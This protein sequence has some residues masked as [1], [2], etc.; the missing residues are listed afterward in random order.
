MPPASRNYP[1][2][3]IVGVGAVILR[4]QQVV[5]VRR[6]SEPLRGRWSLPGGRLELGETLRQGV[7]REVLEET[8]LQVVAKEVLDVFDSIFPD[9]QGKAQFHYVLIDFLCLLRGGEL[10]AG[11][12]VTEAVWACA[13]EL[14]KFELTKNTM[15]VIQKAIRDKQ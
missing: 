4:G 13:D 6:A 8:G 12:D 15:A 10:R 9:S 5:L 1:D 7:E 14:E 2:Q 11:G 3:P